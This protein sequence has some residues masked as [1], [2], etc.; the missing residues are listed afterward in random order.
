MESKIEKLEP[1]KVF[2]YFADICKIP[3]GSGNL[4]GIVDYLVNFAKERNLE[5]VTDDAKN[6]IIYSSGRHFEPVENRRGEAFEPVILQAHTDMVCVKDS[7]ST[8]DLSKDPLDIYVDGNYLK[9]KGTSLGADDGIG[10]AIILSILDD[11]DDKFPPI[12]ALFT[13]DEEN[14]MN[15][16]L[17]IDGNLFKGK[18]LI[19]LDSETEG[20]LTVSCA[21]GTQYLSEI[22]ITREESICCRGEHCEPDYKKY[23]LKISGLLGGHSG[24]EIHKGRA[25]AIIE[26]ANVLKSMEE[27]NIDFYLVSIDAGKFDNVICPEAGCY[28]IVN[29]NDENKFKN[30]ISK[31]DSNLKYEYQLTDKN[32]TLGRTKCPPLHHICENNSVGD[33]I[34]SP[35]VGDDILSSRVGASFTSP[36]NK[37]STHKIID[38]LITIPQGLIEISQ[39]FINIPWT[40]LNLGVIKTE[41]DKIVLSGLIR[42][43][44]DFKRIKLVRRFETIIKNAG[45]KFFDKGHYPA[46]EYNKNSKLKE[47]IL[48]VYKNSYGRD[49]EVVATHGG[50]ESGLFIE[51]IKGLEVVSIGPTMEGVHSIDEKLQIDTVGKLYSF[52]IEYLKDCK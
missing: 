48:K 47:D 52:L 39:E 1:K 17:A 27:E 33:D 35:S 7:N 26:V 30:L 37:N 38:I 18:K 24:M 34:L 43:N 22:P 21:G 23:T 8:K 13:S 44:N 49:M 14:G 46:W 16:A 15:G 4:D 9:A 2:K 32:I 25:N 31:L 41:S 5:Y 29:S 11:A 19:N 20:E 42:S 12:E 40:S 3:H 51:K 45:G 28:V 10:V 50:L 36:L 6:V